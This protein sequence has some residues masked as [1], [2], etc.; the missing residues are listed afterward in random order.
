MDEESKSQKAWIELA[1]NIRDQIKKRAAAMT[2]MSG[3][4]IQA[5]VDGAREAL[6]LE[7]NAILFD[8]EIELEQARTTCAD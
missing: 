2:G 6:F 1:A 8:K 5:F 4:D 7:Q 3:M